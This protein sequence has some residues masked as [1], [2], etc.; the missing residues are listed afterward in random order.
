M[1]RAPPTTLVLEPH[2]AGFFLEGLPAKRDK[3]GDRLVP[4]ESYKKEWDK[5]GW[6]E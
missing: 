2:L 4:G 6:D 5:V 3:T 1:R